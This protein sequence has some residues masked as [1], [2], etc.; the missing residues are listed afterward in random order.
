MTSSQK[1]LVNA[2][3]W[4]TGVGI[5]VGF[6]QAALVRYETFPV[7]QH[8]AH[9]AAAALP[10]Q[11]SASQP[12]PSAERQAFVYTRL[13]DAHTH[14]IKVA[15]VML[16]VAL[17]FPLI[18]IPEG[19]KR[20]LTVLFVVGNVFFPVGVV[21]EIYVEGYPAET[22]AA[23]G[24]LLIIIAFAGFLWGLVRGSDPPAPVP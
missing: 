18:T 16:L 12:T 19:K 4:L 17:L 3:L 2:A 6:L 20:M 7:L 22:L 24:A 21:A 8:R 9:W 14:V 5:I 15:T 23:V 13:I 10:V 1:L 11:D